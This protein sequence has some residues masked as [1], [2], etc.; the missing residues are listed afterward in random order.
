MHPV[1][2]NPCTVCRGHPRRQYRCLNPVGNSIRAQ[3]AIKHIARRL[4]L[5]LFAPDVW[6]NHQTS[7]NTHQSGKP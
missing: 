6:L 5:N 7:L 4:G 1:A 3:R 2:I